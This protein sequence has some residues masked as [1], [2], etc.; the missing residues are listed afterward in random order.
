MT[1]HYPTA[2]MPIGK[3]KGQPVEVL[4]DDP[5]YREWLLGQD[6][7][8]QKFPQLVQIVVNNFAEPENTPEHNRIQAREATGRL[9][10]STTNKSLPREAHGF[11]GGDEQGAHLVE[12]FLVFGGGR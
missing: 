3:F 1:E 4:R 7:F 6:W 5:E 12:R 11:L 9:T 2:I 10:F 8:R